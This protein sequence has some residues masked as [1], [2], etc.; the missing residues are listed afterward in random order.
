MLPGECSLPAP[1]KEARACQGQ[2]ALLAGCGCASYSRRPRRSALRLPLCSAVE[3]G[4]PHVH[5]ARVEYPQHTPLGGQA[6]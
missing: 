4:P 1:R 3:A 5:G 6:L 2:A